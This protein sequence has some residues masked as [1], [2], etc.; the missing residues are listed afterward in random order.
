MFPDLSVQSP[1]NKQNTN[2]KKLLVSKLAKKKK[3]ISIEIPK[4]LGMEVLVLEGK[5]IKPLLEL[6]QYTWQE[7]KSKNIICDRNANV[8]MKTNLDKIYVDYYQTKLISL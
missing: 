7:K 3:R 2:I 4:Y 5:D 6:S 8:N 1:I